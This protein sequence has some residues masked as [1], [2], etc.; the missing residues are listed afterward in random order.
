MSRFIIADFSTRAWP[1]LKRIVLFYNSNHENDSARISWFVANK[2]PPSPLHSV[3]I[4]TS[5][6]YMK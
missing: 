1:K 3:V 2:N 6:T 5:D 4:Y